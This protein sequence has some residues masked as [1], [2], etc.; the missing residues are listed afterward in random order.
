MRVDI[1]VRL[2]PT[3]DI[4]RHLLTMALAIEDREAE[5]SYFIERRDP[6]EATTLLLPQLD[7]APVSSGIGAWASTGRLLSQRARRGEQCANG[8]SCKSR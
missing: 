6:L 3:A 2:V 1:D 7:A 5:G 4:A 8:D